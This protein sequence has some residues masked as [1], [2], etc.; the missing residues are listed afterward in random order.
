[1]IL[2]SLGSNFAHLNL[3]QQDMN[4][5]VNS[6]R[7]SW[8]PKPGTGAPLM[9]GSMSFGGNDP[10]LF[11]HHLGYLVSGSISSGTD[12]KD[13]QIRALADRGSTKGSTVE[14]DRFDGQTAS[15]G[16]LWGGLTNLSTQ[17]GDGSRVFFN[18]MFN[19]SADNDARVENGSFA[20]DAVP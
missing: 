6:L 16:V 18:G 9:N 15:Q 13:G 17:L 12:V 3:Q 19:R 2:R 1:A 14:I 8:T 10:L 4:L 20:A 7:D 5:L 11:G